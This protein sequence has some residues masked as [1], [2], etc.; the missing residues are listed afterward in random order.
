MKCIHFIFT[1]SVLIFHLIFNNSAKQ[2]AWLCNNNY[3]IVE[4]PES[5][6]I[7]SFS[8]FSNFCFSLWVSFPLES[9]SEHFLQT[10]TDHTWECFKMWHNLY[11][12]VYQY[13][14]TAWN[15]WFKWKYCRFWKKKTKKQKKNIKLKLL[16]HC[17]LWKWKER[18][19]FEVL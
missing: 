8:N 11:Y 3:Q 13:F 6:V 18:I 19:H 15:L 10:C 16:F 9:A 7:H 12:K 17:F 1:N 14:E 5:Q 4:K 2:L